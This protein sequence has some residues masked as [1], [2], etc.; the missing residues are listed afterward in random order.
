MRDL[1]VFK[2]LAIPDRP[3]LAKRRLDEADVT[4][5]LTYNKN[6]ITKEDYG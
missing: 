4:S 6:H 3:E 5:L 1:I 2:L